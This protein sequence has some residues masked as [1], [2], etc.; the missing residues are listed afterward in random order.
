MKPRRFIPGSNVSVAV[1]KSER[2]ADV[3]GMF[4]KNLPLRAAWPRGDNPAMRSAAL[5][6]TIA[7]LLG[8]CA[9]YEYDLVQPVAL[10]AHIATK[11]D[12]VVR[13][14][15]LEYRLRTV[16]NRLVVQVFNQ[17]DDDVQLLGERSSVVDPEGQSHPLRGGPIPPHSFLK[18][19]LPPMRPQVYDSGPTWGLGVGVGVGR[20]ERRDPFYD[21]AMAGFHD[22]PRYLSIHDENDTRYWDWNGEGDARLSLVFQRAGSEFK[23]DFAFRRRKM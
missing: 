15:P 17:T 18:L 10:T 1:V 23:Q 5:F 4:L 8:G 19:I 16:D 7:L 12:T 21:P 11:A 2:A 3:P 22:E 13:V 14:D 6:A 9:H 20:S